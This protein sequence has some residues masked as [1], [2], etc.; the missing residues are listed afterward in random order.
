[1]AGAA[2]CVKE[3]QMQLQ[4]QMQLQRCSSRIKAAERSANDDET[5]V[6]AHCATAWISEQ[7]ACDC[8][9]VDAMQLGGSV[10]IVPRAAALDYKSVCGDHR[11]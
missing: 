7:A 5:S 1:M 6:S 10:E 11:T 4:D 8:D 9:A 2:G 3:N